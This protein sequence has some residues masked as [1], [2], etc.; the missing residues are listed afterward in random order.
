MMILMTTI[1]W[2][3]L[4]VDYN[5][6]HHNSKSE[7]VLNRSDRT[8]DLVHHQ[9][10]KW[11]KGERQVPIYPPGHTYISPFTKESH[12]KRRINHFMNDQKNYSWLSWNYGD[13]RTRRYFLSKEKQ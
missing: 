7:F 3:R 8:L 2:D 10:Q 1:N 5:L 12:I 6:T 9:I 4:I 11:S 13:W